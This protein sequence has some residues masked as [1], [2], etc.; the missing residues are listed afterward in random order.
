MKNFWGIYLTKKVYCRFFLLTILLLGTLSTFNAL[1]FQ[2]NYTLKMNVNNSTLSSNTIT[3]THPADLKLTENDSTNHTLVWNL[4]KQTTFDY[5]GVYSFT[6]DAVGGDPTG[7]T[8][9]EPVDTHMDVVLAKDNHRKVIEMYKTTEK[10]EMVNIF[11]PQSVSTQPEIE[12]WVWGDSNARGCFNTGNGGF[13]TH[14]SIWFWLNFTTN[15]VINIY[16]MGANSEVISSDLTPNQWHHFRVKLITSSTFEVWLDGV[17][18]GI[19]NQFVSESSVDRLC[20]AALDTTSSFYLYIDAIDYS[21]APGYYTNRNMDYATLTQAFAIFKNETQMTEWQQWH[22]H[23]EINYN[24]SSSML[25]TGI[26]NISLVFNDAYGQWF[27]DDVIVTIT[28]SEAPVILEVTQSPTTPMYKDYVNIT[29]HI[30]DNGQIQ[31]VYI[32]TNSTDCYPKDYLGLYS[33][34]DDTVGSDPAGWTVTEPVDTHMDVVLA[35]D[36]HR[37]VVE[38]YKTTDKPEMIN[39]FTPQSVSTQPEIEFWVWGDSNARGCFNTGN[40]GFG[41]HGSIWFWMNFTTNKVINIYNMGASSEVISSDLTPNQWHHFRV[42]LVTSSTFEVW[43]D[44]VSLGIHN[45][46]VS[47]PSVDRLCFAALDT[48]SSFYSYIDAIDYSWA[49]GYYTNRNMDY[50]VENEI[51]VNCSMTLL[52]GT[53]Q[54]GTWNYTFK[55]YPLNKQIA[56]RIFVSDTFGNINVTDWNY[57]GVYDLLNPQIINVIQ[58]PASLVVY[59]P[60]KVTT[61]ITENFEIQSVLIES[62]YTGNWINYT[63]ELLSGSLQDGIW[64]Y[65]ISNYPLNR[66]ISYRIFAIDVVGRTN[67]TQYYSFGIFPITQWYVPSELDI[68]FDISGD[69]KGDITFEF[70]N[71]GTTTWVNLTFTI[72]LPP[73]WTTDVA[74]VYFNQ[75]SPG[76]KVIVTFRVTAPENFKKADIALITIGFE[77]TIYETGEILSDFITVAVTGVEVF[78]FFIWLIIIIGSVAAAAATTSFVFIQRRRNRIEVPPIKTKSKALA[79]LEAAMIKDFPGTYSVIS[80]ELMERI[81]SLQGISEYER[82]LL[83]QFISQLDEETAKAWLDE[84]QNIHPN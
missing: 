54:D 63:M 21:W 22:I 46:F 47:E 9:T 64:N 36:N 29:A 53:L 74:N 83:L 6:D 28:E 65:T 35:K 5:L 37:K 39:I 75:L 57:F 59:E 30:T 80:I 56:Y 23:A 3:V 55:N 8:V 4:I 15:K 50:N 49:P 43:L 81:N 18:L 14:G 31:T 11:T 84:F 13:G 79:S 26:H 61:Q 73:G 24:I 40:G 17:S 76:Q 60:I 58:E 77:A 38:M 41:T 34:T 52:N 32:E 70:E 2:T 20:F 45:Q 25:G 10:P 82:T 69:H 42:K 72:Y 66:T 44:G 7:W 48:T 68:D 27:H 1:S 12:F 16:N 62:N 19:H 33:F 71:T 51:F 78:G 67:V